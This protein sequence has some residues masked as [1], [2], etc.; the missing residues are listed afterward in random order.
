MLA[1]SVTWNYFQ[2]PVGKLQFPGS[3]FKL[4]SVQREKEQ[5]QQ[6]TAFFFMEKVSLYCIAFISVHRNMSLN[7]LQS[8]WLDNLIY[9]I[10][11]LIYFKAHD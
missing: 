3:V 9:K 7:N 8:I 10:Q 11:S 6:M 5:L 2:A 1:I 4:F